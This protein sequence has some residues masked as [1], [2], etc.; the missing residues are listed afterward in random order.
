[1]LGCSQVW[2]PSSMPAST[3]RLAPAG[4]AAT[5]LPISKNVA[6]ALLAFKMASSRSVYGVGPSSKVSA[7]HLTCAQSTTS[8]AWANLTC[9]VNAPIATI[10]AAAATA[11]TVRRYRHF[12]LS[13]RFGTGK[14]YPRRLQ[15]CAA[16]LFE[17]LGDQCGDRRPLAAQQGDVREQ[18]VPL[19]LL[20]HGRDAVVAADPEVVALS[21]VV[22]QHHA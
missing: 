22:G 13:G 21:D 2:L 7:T 4:L 12:W 15:R 3:T 14:P 8:L 10:T 16:D 5:L 20:H 9:P 1:M 17:H 6:L 19:E 18:R 11:A